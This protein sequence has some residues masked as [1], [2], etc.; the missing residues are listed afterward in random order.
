MA[1]NEDL[2]KLSKDEL[3]GANVKTNGIN[4]MYIYIY[5]DRHIIRGY[6]YI[7]YIA[8]MDMI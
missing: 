8:P 2:N 5:E 3:K 1:G 7:L 6:I 4:T